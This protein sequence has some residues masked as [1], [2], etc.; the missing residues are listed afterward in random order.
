MSQA[1][2]CDRCH[3]YY[4]TSGMAKGT[5]YSEI[6]CVTFYKPEHTTRHKYYDRRPN[7]DLCPDCTKAL[8]L[9]LNGHSVDGESGFYAT[10][11]VERTAEQRS[12]DDVPYISANDP[13]N[14]DTADSEKESRV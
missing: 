12:Q 7:V 4:T 14:N 6:D 3:D 10:S 9:F 13:R 1:F 5:V 8:Q 11:W 2:Q